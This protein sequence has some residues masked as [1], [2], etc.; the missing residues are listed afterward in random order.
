MI[1]EVIVNVDTLVAVTP[2]DMW[3][4]CVEPLTVVKADDPL[5]MRVPVTA[6][7]LTA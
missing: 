3:P 2:L 6:A 4:P 5:F 1:A 7:W